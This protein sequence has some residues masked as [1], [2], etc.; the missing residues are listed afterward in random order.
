MGGEPSQQ[1]GHKCGQDGIGQDTLL[2]VL[3]K[4]LVVVCVDCNI[5]FKDVGGTLR[6]TGFKAGSS[7]VLSCDRP[8]LHFV[9]TLGLNP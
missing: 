3:E 4:L 5:D 9:F 6:H 7:E 8:C 2:N 1:S